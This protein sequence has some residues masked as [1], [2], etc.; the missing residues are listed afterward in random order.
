[1]IALVRKLLKKTCYLATRLPCLKQV[2]S[3]CLTQCSIIQL[4]YIN[5]FKIHFAIYLYVFLA[6]V[7]TRALPQ[8]P[9]IPLRLNVGGDTSFVTSR[10]TLTAMEGSRLSQ[11]FSGRWDKVL[12]KDS[13]GRIFLD[14]DPVQFRA[15][16]SWLVDIK[17]LP[18]GSTVQGPPLKTLP[19]EYQAG[20]LEL[21]ELLCSKEAS[22]S[23]SGSCNQNGGLLDEG[24]GNVM[25]D[26]QILSS[27]DQQ[28]LKTWIQHE[29]CPSKHCTGNLL[30]RATRDGFA[31]ANFHQKCDGKG[32]TVVIAKSA[33]GHIF[34][35]YTETAWENSGG[36]YKNCND[37]FLFRLSGPGGVGPSQHRIQSFQHGIYCNSNYGPTFGGGHDMVFQNPPV[38][39]FMNLGHTYNQ[40]GFTY[41]AES[42]TATC[43]TLLHFSTC[44]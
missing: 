14:L 8:L 4:Y 37:S 44:V 16:L 21:C 17:R 31:P 5:S 2:D 43:H 34:G 40:N 36:G 9:S 30:F 33:G 1:M 32:P 35:G 24:D 29:S 38:V 41:L 39:N 25:F 20:F 22:N 12:P 28:R 3:I 18:P 27:E 7:I 15:V 23:T 42:Q 19:P 6:V 10:D 13:N 26:S 11:L